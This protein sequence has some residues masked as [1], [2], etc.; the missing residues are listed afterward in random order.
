M[1]PKPTEVIQQLLDLPDATIT[2]HTSYV[3]RILR[4]SGLLGG[5]KDWK[6]LK[7]TKKTP[8]ASLWARWLSRVRK[9]AEK[10]E[11]IAHRAGL[12]L[13]EAHAGAFN[14]MDMKT[15][16]S[17]WTQAVLKL[18]KKAE[19]DGNMETSLACAS[20]LSTILARA[21]AFAASQKDIATIIV[22]RLVPL[23]MSMAQGNPADEP[24]IVLAL[25][26]LL[27][28]G[29]DLRG[30]LKSYGQSMTK[31]CVRCLNFKTTEKVATRLLIATSESIQAETGAARIL[32]RA[33]AT[34][35]KLA[36]H[37]GFECDEAPM[38]IEGV[39][40][41]D[42]LLRVGGKFGSMQQGQE[43][44]HKLLTLLR[45][46]KTCVEEASEIQV[47]PLLLVLQTLLTQRRVAATDSKMRISPMA[48]LG[49]LVPIR[50]AALDVMA[51]AVDALKHHILPHLPSVADAILDVLIDTKTGVASK[52]L[53]LVRQK[54]YYVI[55]KLAMHL[56]L[57]AGRH[58][59]FPMLPHA[60]DDIKRLPQT[61]L[62]VPSL[63]PADDDANVMEPRSKKRRLRKRER[64]NAQLLDAQ[65]GALGPPSTSAASI[66]SV[67]SAASSALECT[68]A[69]QAALILPLESRVDIDLTAAQTYMAISPEQPLNRLSPTLSFRIP[70][71]HF[72][73]G[74]PRTTVPPY[75]L[76]EARA[77]LLQVLISSVLCPLPIA[78]NLH[79]PALPYAL[80]LCEKAA[81]DR[82]PTVRLIAQKGLLAC[83]ATAAF[84]GGY[85]PPV[86]A[87]LLARFESAYVAVA[88]T[89]GETAD[90]HQEDNYDTADVNDSKIAKT[91]GQLS[92]PAKKA[93]LGDKMAVDGNSPPSQPY[94]LDMAT[95]SELRKEMAVTRALMQKSLQA[96]QGAKVTPSHSSG[97]ASTNVDTRSDAKEFINKETV[98]EDTLSTSK[99][100]DGLAASV[101]NP[102]HTTRTAVTSPPAPPAPME[103]SEEPAN[104]ER[105]P[106]EED[107][108]A[109]FADD[110][111]DGAQEEG[112]DEDKDGSLNE[113]CEVDVSA[114]PDEGDTGRLWAL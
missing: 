67:A 100:I 102:G 81:V 29:R 1:N 30:S 45:L 43:A 85:S 65:S 23:L 77:S 20:C 59:V 25:S 95:M 84:G 19:I 7:G 107:I 18:L 54:A 5:H 82:T 41:F 92:N 73:G 103:T 60:L 37:M 98:P 97:G 71:S 39:E 110:S 38:G 70:G 33:H 27:R 62:S 3:T 35:L 105:D 24:R 15:C 49:L 109:A 58:V 108:E 42:D 111:D 47:Q 32:V 8:G 79:S 51:A 56:G 88:E 114:G 6:N 76:P 31:L 9:F 94:A 36:I 83:R 2:A 101:K 69:S 86:P 34:C 93:E 22:P 72:Q 26:I 90:F 4:I 113:S 87:S 50:A 14:G 57:G 46:I 48:W 21:Q 75:L 40:Q 66:W 12:A 10:P 16:A 11:V 13:M 104:Q 64:V 78:G 89:A 63:V 112:L 80:R 55:G 106:K 52:E 91:D 99:G 61:L 28:I 68:L 44:C 53:A 17:T 74:G 96:L